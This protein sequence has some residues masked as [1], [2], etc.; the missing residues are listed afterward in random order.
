MGA[1]DGACGQRRPPQRTHWWRIS[2]RTIRAIAIAPPLRLRAQSPTPDS[3][4]I[5]RRARAAERSGSVDI[6]GTLDGN[7]RLRAI[8]VTTFTRTQP[9]E[10]TS[11]TQRTDVRI[12]HDDAAAALTERR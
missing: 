10:A 9:I 12:L 5:D 3:A 6:D 4:T 2:R 8:P 11:A 1:Q 7:A